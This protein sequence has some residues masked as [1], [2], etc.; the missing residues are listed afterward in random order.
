MN[1]SLLGL[2]AGQIGDERLDDAQVGHLLNV[3][4]DVGIRLIDT[5]PSYGISEARI[6][7]HLAHRRNEFVLSTK[8]GYGIDGVA[9]WS[10]ECI[11]RGIERALQRLQTDHIDI[12]FLHSC[13]L[14]VLQ[15]GEVI[16][17]LERA[18]QAG[19]IGCAGYSGENEAL[20]FALASGR[21]QAIE[22]SLNLCDQKGIDAVVPQARAAGIGV[23]AKR[24]VANTPWR[25]QERPTGHY[26]DEYWQRWHAMAVDPQGQDWHELALRFAAWHTGAHSCIVGTANVEHLR[27]NAAVVARGHLPG[28]SVQMLR[29]AFA[30]HGAQW[31]GQV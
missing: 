25:Y 20:H 17:A 1:V 27:R 31:F 29:D 3:A 21:F 10:G 19:K 28:P 15:R 2:G 11:T 22:T 7:R 8:F 6:G 18:R 26:V 4:L 12:A 23:I 5:A 30:R 9:D 13:E 16:D 14:H 24:P